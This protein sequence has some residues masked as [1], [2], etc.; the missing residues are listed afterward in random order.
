LNDVNDRRKKKVQYRYRVS[1]LC[2][3]GPSPI[4]RVWAWSVFD[5]CIFIVC[6]LIVLYCP[7]VSYL[8][9]FNVVRGLI[10]C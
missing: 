6:V 2:S 5:Y 10:G 9:Q 7:S 4:R 3:A 8:T 1:R